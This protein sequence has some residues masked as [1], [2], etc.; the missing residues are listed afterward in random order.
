MLFPAISWGGE[1]PQ[2]PKFPLPKKTP[3]IQNT[4]KIHRIYSSDMCPPPPPPR[5]WSLELTLF[6]EF[7]TTLNWNWFECVRASVV[8][9]DCIVCQF[10]IEHT[11]CNCISTA[12]Y[13][14]TVEQVPSSEWRSNKFNNLISN[15]QPQSNHSAFKT[16]LSYSWS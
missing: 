5:T 13:R 1:S 10:S 15:L 7:H 16:A 9:R 6:Y 8:H 2:N 14:M 12:I 3:K 11:A 4:L